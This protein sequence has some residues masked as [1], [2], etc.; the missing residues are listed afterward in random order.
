[1]KGTAPALLVICVLLSHP[2]A[3]SAAGSSF[4]EDVPVRG[5]TAALAAAAS[6]SPAPDNARFVAELARVVYSWPQTGPYSNEPVRR[7]ITAFFADTAPA[8]DIQNVPVPLSAALWS[9]AIFHRPISPDG[10]VGAILT[11]RS[12]ALMC[13]GLA[14]MD[15]ETLEFFADHAS[16]LGRLAERAPSAFAAFAESL[17]IRGGRVVVPGGGDTAAGWEGVVGEKVDRPE[18]FIQQLFESDR[19]RLAYLYDVLT[20]LDPRMLALVFGEKR[21]T[22]EA[23]A[24]LKRLAAIARRA[25]PEWDVTTAPFVRAPTDLA[26]FFARL[27]NASDPERSIPSVGSA[28]FWQ[29]I[30]EETGPIEAGAAARSAAGARADLVTLAETT[31]LHPAR[32]RERR[33]DLLAFAQRVFPASA[34]ESDA[35]PAIRGLGPFPVLMLTLERMGVRTPAIYAAAGRQAERLTSLDAGRGHT[36]LAQ[37]QGALALLARVT[38]VG[39]I[40]APAAERLLQDLLAVNVNDDGRYD[41]GIAA[42]MTGKLRPALPAAAS[43]DEA[44]LAAAAG[45]RSTTATTRVEWE[46][47]RYRVDPGG[48]ELVR[49]ARARTRQEEATFDTV[50]GVGALAQ[51]LIRQP[52]TLGSV[53]EAAAK[54]TA[55]ASELVTGERTAD[56]PSVRALREASQA[57]GGIRRPGDLSE[58]KRAG[59][60][61]LPV[62]DVLLGD[63]LL[64]LAYAFDLGDPEGTILI[65]GDPSRRH[66]FGYSLPARDAR[67]KAMWS[68][69]GI[70][71][72]GGPW[73]LVGSALALDMAMA[74]LA[75]RRISVDRVPESPMLNLMHRDGFAAT[76][77]V[78]NPRSLTDADRD[79]IAERIER[80]A[81][82]VRAVASGGEPLEPV[83]REIDLDG[84]RTRALAWTVAH[85][86]DRVPALF[87][88]VELLVLGGGSPAAF[89]SWG[90]YAFR[91]AGC[92]CPKLSP[93]GEWRHWWGLTQAGLPATLVADLPLRVAVVLHNLQLP[94]V[95]AKPVL[96]AAMQDFVDSINPTDGNEWLTLSRA[97]QAVGPERFE[98]YIAAATADG[99]LLPDP[100]GRP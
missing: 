22:P 63:A 100:P 56:D 58:A 9:Q 90:T 33:V 36:A 13:Y 85:E 15:D 80:G 88:M 75:L 83:V 32:E 96:A 70:E 47:Q 18:R 79:S 8:A 23:A 27:R 86:A 95:L 2:A 11:D 69:A 28:A 14:G 1:V 74:Q 78:M 44:L 16:L 97:A 52:A 30:F 60:Q 76:V 17:R 38:E 93:P 7:R 66:D 73:H 67:V 3:A 54:L 50:F 40:D 71:T 61:L 65:A 53:Q 20:H 25:F 4:T 68:V 43:S 45:V 37:F 55:V 46:G 24:S 39:T 84:W 21:D 81:K 59:T 5:G 49:L 87:S 41:G 77:A 35:F 19:G 91:T 94:A 92:L 6:V 62:A 12:A 57:L 98:D 99:P 72:R 64:S 29:R 34:T 31:L 42:W 10:L 26:A 51:T 89:D 82:R 48:A